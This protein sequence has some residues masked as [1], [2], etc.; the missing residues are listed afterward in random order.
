MGLSWADLTSKD[1]VGVRICLRGIS[2]LTKLEHI[3]VW[4]DPTY[5]QEETQ[6]VLRSA[7]FGLAE[8]SR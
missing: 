7:H 5:R 3:L 2:N 1:A 8:Q 6:S 4:L